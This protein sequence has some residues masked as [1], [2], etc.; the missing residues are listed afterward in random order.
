M[1]LKLN[2]N[3]FYKETKNHFSI[4]VNFRLF[5]ERSMSNRLLTKSRFKV[6][7]ECATKLFYLD[8][9]DYGSTK[10]NNSFL[11]ALAEGGF[12]V[13]ELAKI[14]HPNGIEVKTK[15]KAKA[16]QQT[17][18]LLKRDKVVIFEPAF[19]FENLFIRVDILI[20]NGNYL[21]LIEVKAKS[22]NP[23]V[24]NHFYTKS[25]V[26]KGKPKISS[27]WE[28]YL[29]DVAF[30]KLVLTQAMPAF[31]VT[32]FLMLADKSQSAS[33]DG[34]NQKFFLCKDS[35]D[36][37]ISV[38]V[39]PD[40]SQ[41][42][43]GTPLLKKIQV[44]D[45]VKLLW[46]MKYPENRTFLEH[47][48][49][50]SRV[51]STNEFVQPVLSVTCK[52]CEFKIGKKEKLQNL[53][54]GFENCWIK[55]GAIT[56]SEI[57]K[58]LVLDIWNFRGVTDLIKD[59]KYFMENLTQKD[60]AVR[61]NSSTA[62]GLSSAERQWLQVKKVQTQDQTPF[63][64]LQGLAQQFV[65]WTFPLH[66]ID[67][68]TTMV[69]IPFNKGRQPYE[70]VAFQ[71]SHH[72]VYQNGH[73][74]HKDQYLNQ[75]RGVFPNFNFLRELKKALETDQGTVFRY[76]AHEN[77]VLCQI[78]EQLLRTPENIAD[79]TELIAFIESLT[80][81][82]ND[83]VQNW[84]GKRS[85]VDL[86]EL[87]KRYYYHPLTNG[88]NSIKHV[89]PAILNDSLFLQQRY[90]AP[91]YGSSQ[92]PS[93]NFCNWSWIKKDQH[94]KVL[95]PYKCLP[96]LFSDF[97]ECD[98]DNFNTL[99]TEGSI[100]DGGAAMTAYARMQFTQMTNSEVI[101]VTQALLKYC[102]L[103]TLAM[104]MIYEYWANLL[105]QAGLL[106]DVV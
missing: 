66:F 78:R 58:P 16:L 85:M 48:I 99:F 30:Q 19:Q 2:I 83:S 14:Y 20:K 37:S 106:K 21:E 104:V 12:Q 84:Q 29:L 86:C 9:T 15:D 23:A 22:M 63:V 56:S 32:S 47:V 82:T 77:T 74:E 95:D 38:K 93:K 103:D 55:A 50:L 92:F 31:K 101:N 89:L 42:T 34:L 5:E 49:F 11:K 72:I 75:D 91:H 80:I 98:F 102:E 68:E 26:K 79:R 61:S 54:S 81:S 73:I 57:A 71:F 24:S 8:N 87:V 105:E 64:N 70:Q 35:C 52:K 60:F 59:Q 46:N 94:G 13:G 45:E 18:Q 1:L 7:C 39:A 4:K 10:N 33:I 41:E 44:D 97:S 67:F 51:C 88:C 43:V 65:S 100:N 76:A 69:A 96:P 3:N 53:K 62:E 90:A 27:E 28:A 25:S 36:N 6:G 40:T 17:D